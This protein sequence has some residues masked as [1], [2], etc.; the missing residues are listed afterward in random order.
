MLNNLREEFG[1]SDEEHKNIEKKII[2][3]LNIKQNNVAYLL[4]Y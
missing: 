4:Y 3:E 1:I 2:D